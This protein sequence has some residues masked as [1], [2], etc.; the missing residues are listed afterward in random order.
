MP[1]PHGTRI[2]YFRTNSNFF[3]INSEKPIYKEFTQGGNGAP[4]V[5][6]Q[7]KWPVANQRT[8]KNRIDAVGKIVYLVKFSLCA[9]GKVICAMQITFCAV[10]K[11]ICGMEIIF[12]A[13]G[14]MIRAMKIT[15]CALAKVIRAM[16]IIFC[17]AKKVIHA[18]EIIFSSVE[19]VIGAMEI[20]FYGAETGRKSPGIKLE[21]PDSETGRLGDCLKAGEEV[22]NH[23]W[24]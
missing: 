18:A 8:P 3:P 15:F 17:A 20:T 22:F 19:K 12:R 24:T 9:V 14:I 4:G 1:I 11:T 6:A 16:E 10:D 5:E 2:C 21:I 13:V 7:R 23:R